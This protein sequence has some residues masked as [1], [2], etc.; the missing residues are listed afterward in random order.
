MPSFRLG[1]LKCFQGRLRLRVTLLR[2]LSRPLLA[3]LKD[4]DANFKEEVITRHGGGDSVRTAD[5]RYM[6]MRTKNGAGELK[7]IGLFDLKKDPQENQ[8]VSAD[9]AYSEVLQRMRQKLT[10]AK[11]AM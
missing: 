5:F 11:K 10:E 9:P 2:P 6:E 4:V 3:L 8:D 1:I 7:G